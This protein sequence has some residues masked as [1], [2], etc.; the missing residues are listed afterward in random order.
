VHV[1]RPKELDEQPQGWVW[2]ERLVGR[3]SGTAKAA[4][5]K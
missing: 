1:S 3:R 2:I 5:M 4:C